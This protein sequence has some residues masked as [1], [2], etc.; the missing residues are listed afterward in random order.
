VQPGH[1]TKLLRLTLGTSGNGA[2]G[3][4]NCVEVDIANRPQL[5][6]VLCMLLVHYMYERQ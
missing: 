2:D 6:E 3:D 1:L 5:E 4:A